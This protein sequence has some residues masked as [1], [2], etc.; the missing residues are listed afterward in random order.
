MKLRAP[1]Q[2]QL[3]ILSL[4]FAVILGS[5]IRLLIPFMAG[6]P[7][8]DGG[9]FYQILRTLQ[10]NHLRL[11]AHIPYNGLSIPFA[12]PPLAFYLGAGLSLLLHIDAMD[13][14]R[15]LPAVVVVVSIPAFYA[16]SRVWL[17]S[18]YKAGIA[19]LVFAG[20]PRTISWLIMGG[21]LT[22]SLGYLFLLLTLRSVFLLFSREDRKFLRPA[23][24]FGS[25]TVLTHP[26]AAL[27][28]VGLCA[29]TWLF[30]GR[31]QRGTLNAFYVGL[32]TFVLTGIWWLPLLRRLG[33]QPILAATQTGHH[34]LFSLIYPALFGLTEEQPLTIVA[35]LG[36]IGILFELVRKD[37]FLPAAYALPFIIEPRSSPLQAMTAL[38][39]LAAVALSDVILPA[40]SKWN[41]WA[42]PLTL[43][44]MGSAM[45]G[46]ML[47]LGARLAGAVVLPVHQEALA[48]VRENTPTDSRF[49]LLS[50]NPAFF[51]DG[52]SE[53]FPAL[54]G[55][56][57]V[58][59]IQGREWLDGEF[60]RASGHQIAIQSCLTQS[61]AADCIEQETQ[62]MGVD[63][64]YVYVVR[65]A[66]PNYCTAP[67]QN[68]EAVLDLGRRPAYVGVYQDEDVII[69]RR[70]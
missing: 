64:D 60:A 47:N 5:W 37:Y 41:R 34:T 55:R 61:G 22:R 68:N 63:Y 28:A 67:T 15:W 6:F 59:T 56:I 39:M 7:I 2:E 32:G 42:A 33:L 40:F 54:T 26:E 69:F 62:K 20:T 44:A 31:S 16:L 18:S 51:C 21:G 53:W 1:S 4:W 49:L 43:L 29:L 57:S 65:K 48:W 30:K 45:F 11:P 58:T 38:A 66:S 19:A 36:L 13:I 70:R 52:L 3:G 17:D 25:L 8:N 10:E 23:I 27:H 14:L 35:V 50:G 12:Y 46:N 24:L 9:L